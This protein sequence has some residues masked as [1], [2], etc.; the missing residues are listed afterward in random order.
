MSLSQKANV[1]GTDDILSVL[2]WSLR[3]ESSENF[4]L[5]RVK[6]DPTLVMPKV[7]RDQE[8]N[9]YQQ[10][11]IARHFGPLHRHATTPIPRIGLEEVHGQI[12][13]S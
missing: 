3:E 2:Y 5:Y 1:D 13:S 7:F 12:E 8:M 10:L 11:D 9:I 4:L 6:L